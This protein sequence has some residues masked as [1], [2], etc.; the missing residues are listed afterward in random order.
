MWRTFLLGRTRRL[1]GANAVESFSQGLELHFQG[2]NF[3][4]L[5]KHHIAQLGNCMLEIRY[6]RLHL[7]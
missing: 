2:P 4:V 3:L 1:V 7:L 6:F 5:A